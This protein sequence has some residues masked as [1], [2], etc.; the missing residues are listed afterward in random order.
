VL[1][2]CERNAEI[3]CAPCHGGQWVDSS[4][5]G[6]HLR[7]DSQLRERE[8]LRLSIV[9]VAKRSARKRLPHQAGEETGGDDGRALSPRR[10]VVHFRPI[11]G[12]KSEQ[13]RPAQAGGM[14]VR[15][16]SKAAFLGGKV[17]RA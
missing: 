2:Q 7:V 13:K 16:S 4:R 14:I 8:Y 9:G 11:L 12:D 5:R 3:C 17:T 15:S 10:G 1:R 6:S